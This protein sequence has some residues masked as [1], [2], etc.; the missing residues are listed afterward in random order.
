MLDDVPGQFKRRAPDTTGGAETE[1]RPRQEETPAEATAETEEDRRLR[2]KRLLDDVP[3]Q[4]KRNRR[5]P[6]DVAGEGGFYSFFAEGIHE[7]LD[8]DQGIEVTIPL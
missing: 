5:S 3:E 6:A 8:E 1:Q 2:R 7:Q 4:F